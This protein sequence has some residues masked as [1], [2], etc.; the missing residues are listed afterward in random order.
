MLDVTY[1]KST[2]SKTAIPDNPNSIGFY[3]FGGESACI[4][5]DEDEA[6]RRLS[7]PVIL[8]GDLSY[9]SQE[10]ETVTMW[11]AKSKEGGFDASGTVSTLPPLYKRIIE[12]EM[13]I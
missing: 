13:R 12:R 3:C 7:E 4:F 1:C 9:A 8:F 5:E 10:V 2:R 6:V 11:I